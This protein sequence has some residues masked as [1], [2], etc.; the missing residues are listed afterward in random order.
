MDGRNR[1]EGSVISS[2]W[3]G[4]STNEVL[5]GLIFVTTLGLQ[6]DDGSKGVFGICLK[7]DEEMGERYGWLKV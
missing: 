1:Y 5:T 3:L 7:E 4:I 2:P 6:I